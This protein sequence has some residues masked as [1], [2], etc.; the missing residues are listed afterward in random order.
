MVSKTIPV[1]LHPNFTKI[2]A[3]FFGYCL[4]FF[5]S[6]FETVKRSYTIPVCFYQTEQHLIQAP[7][8]VQAIITGSRRHMHYFNHK[9]LAINID[10][11]GYELGDHH[12]FLDQAN[13]FLPEDLK[14]VE[15]IPSVI[16]ISILEPYEIKT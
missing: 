14:M 1:I 3:L 12:I 8:T 7:E 15:L 2:S 11:S 6:N 5:F 10:L 9:N 13:L 16:S 4:W